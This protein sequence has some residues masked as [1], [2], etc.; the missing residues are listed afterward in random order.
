MPRKAGADPAPSAAAIS[1]SA[2]WSSSPGW[3]RKPV[4][5]LKSPAAPRSSLPSAQIRPTPSDRP[6]R[7]RH[8]EARRIGIIDR[9]RPALAAAA[10]RSAFDQVGRPD[11]GPGHPHR[12]EQL[13]DLRAVGRGLHREVAEPRPVPRLGRED[14]LVD[15][16]AERSSRSR[17]RSARR[18]AWPTAVRTRVA[19]SAVAPR[20][21]RRQGN[22]RRKAPARA[23]APGRSTTRRRPASRAGSPIP[24]RMPRWSCAGPARHEQHV[25]RLQRLPVRGGPF[26][27]PRTRHSRR[28]RIRCTHS[29]VA[30][31]PGLIDPAAITATPMQ[32]SPCSRRPSL[33]PEADADQRPRPRDDP[34]AAPAHRVRPRDSGSEGRFRADAARRGN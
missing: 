25:A 34:L 8:R 4:A 21:R 11:H 2:A 32:S 9:L 7:Q 19:I 24:V 16:L 31:H 1:G 30:A 3:S 5:L 28:S 17:R 18:Q 29:V 13:R 20:R 26:R 23:P 6:G 10:G 22:A 27:T 15:R 33:R 12:P 14:A